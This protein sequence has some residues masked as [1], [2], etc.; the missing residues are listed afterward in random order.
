MSKSQ[1]PELIYESSASN[2]GPGHYSIDK[3]EGFRSLIRKGPRSGI[4]YS[5]GP[6]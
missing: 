6:L 3:L 1:R 5:L 2:L 4:H